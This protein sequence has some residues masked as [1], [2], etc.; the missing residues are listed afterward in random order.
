M[1]KL[2][3]LLVSFSLWEIGLSQTQ[4][5]FRNFD[6]SDGLSSNQVNFLMQDSRGFLWI[7]TEFGLNRFDGVSF[8]KWF[9]IPR[10]STSLINIRAI[11]YRIGELK[12][13]VWNFRHVL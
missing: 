8:E 4:Y 6:T 11:P 12:E 13:R 10:D 5:R 3:I 9:H 1:K 2:F 7:G